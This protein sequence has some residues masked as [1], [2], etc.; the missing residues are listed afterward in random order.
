MRFSLFTLTAKAQVLLTPY[1]S[2]WWLEYEL[3]I[4]PV[5]EKS[6]K[7]LSTKRLS[8]FKLNPNECE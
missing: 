1:L 5:A 4:M 8:R 7:N 3:R 2:V 6:R